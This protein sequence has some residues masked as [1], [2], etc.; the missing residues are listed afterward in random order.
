MV[1]IQA[2]IKKRTKGS[3]TSVQRRNVSTALERFKAKE[4]R[5]GRSV[6]NIQL[7]KLRGE[8]EASQL[9]RQKR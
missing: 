8:L 5:Q 9:R 3:L 6:N 1:K 7:S 2:A 4:K